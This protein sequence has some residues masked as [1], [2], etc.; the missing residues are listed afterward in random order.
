MSDISDVF[1]AFVCKIWCS[2]TDSCFIAF[3]LMKMC[4]G[5]GCILLGFGRLVKVIGCV[6]IGGK[7][8]LFGNTGNVS[9]G[10]ATS[11]IRRCSVCRRW[12]IRSLSAATSLN[13]SWTR[14]NEKIGNRLLLGKNEYRVDHPGW[15]LEMSYFGSKNVILGRFWVKTCD[16]RSFWVKKVNCDHF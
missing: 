13:C 5:G 4:C 1:E 2:G 7:P 12:S 15:F 10:G 6:I 3:G 16:F 8:G 14:W 9:F 11:M